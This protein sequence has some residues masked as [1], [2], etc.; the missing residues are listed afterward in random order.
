MRTHAL[1]GVPPPGRSA[2][3]PAATISQST[4]TSP[5]RRARIDDG[6]S[7][8]EHAGRE[9]DD[10]VVVGRLGAPEHE[11]VVEADHR[12][13]RGVGHGRER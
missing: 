11:V 1:T 13:G 3:G 7:I 5:A 4:G 9:G 12:V 10:A 6:S 2:S 8:S